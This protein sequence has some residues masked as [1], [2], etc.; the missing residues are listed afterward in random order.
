MAGLLLQALHL[1]AKYAG[2]K[3][4]V[5]LLLGAGATVDAAN[6]VRPPMQLG[7]YWGFFKSAVRSHV[8]G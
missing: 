7:T 8:I 3:E 6:W 5:E 2:T 4:V 1:A